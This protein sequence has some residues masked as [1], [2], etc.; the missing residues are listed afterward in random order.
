M[1]YTIRAT[2]TRPTESTDRGFTYAI[3]QVEGRSP[4]AAV[5]NFINQYRNHTDDKR[6]PL[7]GECSDYVRHLHAVSIDEHTDGGDNWPLGLAGGLAVDGVLL[8]LE[9]A[10]PTTLQRGQKVMATIRAWPE[11]ATFRRYTDRGLVVIVVE[12]T[13]EIVTIDPW[14]VS[15][16]PRRAH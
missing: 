8:T 11:P 3:S 14:L 6:A 13:R 15:A 7:T 5:R 2:Q 9:E 12:A 4:R 1:L 10:K 16:N